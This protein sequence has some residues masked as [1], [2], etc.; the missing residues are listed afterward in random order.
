MSDSK[1]PQR[2]AYWLAGFL[3][4]AG[5]MHFVRPKQYDALVPKEL[6]GER[7]Q[8]TYASGAV[9]LG[10]AAAIALP[11]T[12]RLGGFAA[13]LLFVGVFPGNV[14]MALDYER[15]KKPLQV[16]AAAWFRLTAQWPLV[17]WALAVRDNA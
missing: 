4:S 15:T 3:A 12:R 8:W 16:R 14:K 10:V 7:R 6:P 17:K 9:E 1:R 13:A 2:P 5:V 11:K